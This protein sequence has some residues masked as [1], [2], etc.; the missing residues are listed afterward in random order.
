VNAVIAN[1]P[2]IGGAVWLTVVLFV[3]AMVV[4]TVFGLVCGLARASTVR[5]IAVAAMVYSWFWRVLPVLLVLYFVFYGLPTV[6]ITL[7]AL[8]AG[9]LVF[10]LS[11]AAYMGEIVRG[12]LQ[13]VPIEQREAAA[14]LG[15]GRVRT[16]RRVVLPYVVR[17]IAGPYIS[18][19]ILVLK[20]TS[21]AGIIGVSELTLVTRGL[22]NT[23]YEVWPFLAVSA[24]VYLVISLALSSLQRVVEER[25]AW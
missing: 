6:G 19:A 15:M 18:Q 3:G 23:T 17:S 9:I 25:S 16:F 21:I 10:G 24:L 20:G 11:T 1:L 13:A 14:A 2:S 5:P 7:G 8:T 12:G 4:G 22:I